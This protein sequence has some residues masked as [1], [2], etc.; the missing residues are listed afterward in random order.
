METILVNYFSELLLTNGVVI[1]VGVFV[2]GKIIKEALDF[3][4]NKYIPLIGGLAGVLLAVFIPGIFEDK[5]TVTK[6]VMGLSL[7][8][9]A[10]GGYETVRNLK[11]TTETKE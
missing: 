8:W 7:G 6:A 5:D 4:P 1:A 9:A 10:T 2:L 11:V 3:I